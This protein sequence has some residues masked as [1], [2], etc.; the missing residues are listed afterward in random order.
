ME[1][2]KRARLALAIV[3]CYAPLAMASSQDNAGGLMEDSQLTIDNR[4]FAFK[5]RQHGVAD[6][7][8]RSRETAGGAVAAFESGYTQGTMGVG[9]DA[10]GLVGLRLDSGRGQSGETLFPETHNGRPRHDLSRAGAAL[11]VRLSDTTLKAGEQFVELPVFSTDDDRL[12]PETAQGILLTSEEIDDLTL[13]AGHFTRLS[14]EEASRG[15]SERL[16]AANVVGGTYALNDGWE[17]ELYHSEVA[18]HFRKWYANVNGGWQLAPDNHL[19]LDASSYRT[20]S[21]GANKTGAWLSNPDG[22]AR[23]LDNLASSLSLAYVTS[24]QRFTVAAQRVSGKGGYAHGIDGGGSVW[25]ANSA[26][27]SD[28]TA[29]N[30]R[31]WQLGHDYNFQD[32]GAPGLTLSTR[33][34]RS[35]HARTLDGSSGGA[36]ERDIDLA[37]VIQAGTLKDLSLT[38]RHASYRASTGL[39]EGP[40]ALDELRL[41]VSYP[42]ALL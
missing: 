9:F 19:L 23:K 41:I 26:T 28:F 37:Y 6:A 21:A 7:S 31:S 4:L 40:K 1:L 33:Y 34:I 27:L 29:E 36:W 11:K 39:S 30:E 10:I 24:T 2:S 35:T 20:R 32:F 17:I 38:A 14:A 25:L 42:L 15:D 3:A 12:L 22:S 13:H 5:Q 8:K 16:T 18:D